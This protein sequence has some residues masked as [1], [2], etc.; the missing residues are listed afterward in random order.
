ML[1]GVYDPGEPTAS[2][3]SADGF[4]LMAGPNVQPSDGNPTVISILRQLADGP[5]NV[6]EI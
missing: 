4:L 5:E 1:V 6:P 3:L 2:V